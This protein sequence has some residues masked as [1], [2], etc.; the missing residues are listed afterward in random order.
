M[1]IQFVLAI[2][3][4]FAQDGHQNVCTKGPERSLILESEAWNLG[5]FSKP[6]WEI[7]YKGA[8]KSTS[9]PQADPYARQLQ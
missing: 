7:L 8:L 9:R 1:G 2:E 6:E 3:I 4:D 5:L